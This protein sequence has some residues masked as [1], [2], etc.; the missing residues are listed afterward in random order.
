MYDDYARH[1]IDLLPNLPNFDRDECRRA[2]SSAYYFAIRQQLGQQDPADVGGI[3]SILRRLVDALESVAVF[4]SLNGQEVSEEVA[5]ASAFVAAEALSLSLLL[6]E[7]SNPS[8]TALLFDSRN[9]QALE[10]ALLYMIG[11]Y[12]VNAASVSEHIRTTSP[13]VAARDDLSTYLGIELA[14]A[15]SVLDSLK[16]LCQGEVVSSTTLIDYSDI[17]STLPTATYQDVISRVRSRLNLALYEAIEAY[18]AWLRGADDASLESAMGSVRRVQNASVSEHYGG[19]SEFSEYY[20]LSSLVLAAINRTNGRSLFHTTPPPPS[21]D[22][23][24]LASFRDYLRT[25]STGTLSMRGRPFLWPTALEYINTCLPGPSVGAVISMPTGSGKS[26]LAELATVHALSSGWVLYLAPTNAL[27]NQ[28]RRDLTL[29]L[30][31]FNGITVRSFVGGEEYTSFGIEEVVSGSPHYVSV[32]TPEK[33]MLAMRLYPDQFAS[34]SLCVFDECHLL[35]E[36]ERGAY[37]DVVMAKLSVLATSVIYLLMSAMLSN[38]QELAEWLC[39]IQHVRSV[40]LTLTWRPTRTLRGLLAVDSED[41][42]RG[43]SGAQAQLPLLPPKRVNVEFQARLVLVAGLSGPWN[44]HDTLD[45]R[46]GGLPIAIPARATKKSENKLIP[47]WKN[48]ASRLLAELFAEHGLSTICFLLTSKHHAFS[49]AK[50]TIETIGHIENANVSLPNDI[51]AWLSIAD[52]ELGIGTILRTFLANGIAV[53]TSAMLDA[54]RIASEQMFKIGRARLMFATG[55]LSQGLNLPATAVVISGT[56]MGDIRDHDPERNTAM[57]LNSFGRAG[58]PGFSNQG[59]AILVTD[60]PLY[61]GLNERLDPRG[62]LHEYP[63]LQQSDAAVSIR[64][65]LEQLIDCLLGEDLSVE[66]MTTEQIQQSILLS[67]SRE[68]DSSSAEVLTKTF[69]AYRKHAQ[70]QNAQFAERLEQISAQA[71]AATTAGPSWLLNVAGKA[72]VP[73]SMA[74]HMYQAYERRGRVSAE[75]CQTLSTIGWVQIFGEVMA[76]MPVSE[77]QDYYWSQDDET[78]FGRMKR[79]VHFGPHGDH[80]PKDLAEWG[81]LWQEFFEL[82]QLF[83]IGSTYSDIAGRLLGLTSNQ[84]SAS[85]SDGSDPIPKVFNF[86]SATVNKLA[87]AAGSFLAIN[88]EIALEAGNSANIPEQLTVLPICIRYG[89][90]SVA[91]LYWYRFGFHNRACAHALSAHFPFPRDHMDDSERRRWISSVLRQIVSDAATDFT[92]DPILAHVRT[93]RREEDI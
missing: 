51:A 69:A 7:T 70:A 9:Y 24:F 66:L 77:T 22:P 73:F 50:N 61:V 43:H 8:E 21:D 1:L 10:A 38:P 72:G 63:V 74:S 28:I 64:S 20:H 45:Y 30:K 41:F 55:T 35:G 65:P 6:A 36:S 25:R 86:L 59:V 56:S 32:M 31:P 42:L 19:Y 29:A 76:L 85:R 18:L 12:D 88:E 60:E 91:T 54:E 90:N 11:G 4:D 48:L 15:A 27:A 58:R 92:P 80:E 49:S 16:R 3:R 75:Q 87:I 57:I 83:M 40:P 34:C 62:I 39:Q 14:T 84:V 37:S 44:L 82:I 23:R 2:L 26:F 81:G 17:L 13:S 68:S 46:I 89:L 53:H 33:C 47:R 71:V 5:N 93:I 52:A 67:Q 79:A 78:V